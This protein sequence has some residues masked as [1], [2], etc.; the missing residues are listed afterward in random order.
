MDENGGMSVHDS[1][2]NNNNGTLKGGIWGLGKFNGALTLQ[3]NNNE[4]VEGCASNFGFADETFT[5]CVWIKT[6]EDGKAIIAQGGGQSGWVVLIQGNR[7]RIILKNDGN[8]IFEA[9][10]N[11]TVTDGKWHLIVASI[12]TSTTD[13]SKNN[14]S[15]Y[16]DGLSNMQIFRLGVYIPSAL[17]WSIGAREQNSPSLFWKGS[18]DD[19][20]IYNRS[21]SRPEVS[22]LY[23]MGPY[24]NPDSIS[25]TDYY[26]FTDNFTGNTMLARITNPNTTS[27]D[28]IL[29]KCKT[30]FYYN[31]LRFESNNSATLNIWTNLGQP[32]FIANGVWNTENYTTTLTLDASTAGELDWNRDPP[33]ALNS[34]LSSTIIGKTVIFSSL[35]SDSHSLTGGGFVFS[36]NNTGQWVNASWAA[37]SSNPCWGNAYFNFKQ[38]CWSCCWF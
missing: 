28:N 6:K 4:Y 18:I 30:F 21:L 1:S 15:I 19:V 24:S 3:G 5:A 2:G 25:F 36:S 27:E 34:F 26:N 11:T 20:R 17:N 8:T 32:A 13:S 33:F 38:Q 14:A 9:I 16:V 7:S 35:W 23:N 12:T 10:D 37:F 22:L 31:K 29:V